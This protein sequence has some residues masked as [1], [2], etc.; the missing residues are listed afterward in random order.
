MNTW[1][2]TD[3]EGFAVQVSFSE[4]CPDG[5]W[6]QDNNYPIFGRAGFKYKP[7]TQEW[8]ADSDDKLKFA[9]ELK[10]RS[11][12]NAL[13]TE[14]DWTQNRDVPENISILWQ[15]YRQQLRD[16]T[17]QSGYPFNVVWPTPPA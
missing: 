15:P 12:R 1:L 17:D 3:A 9:K 10:I 6:I 4:F 8:I 11:Q 2:K 14:T 7:S 16:I 5:N 13:L